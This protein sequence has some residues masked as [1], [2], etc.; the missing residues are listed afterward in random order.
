MVG[1]GDAFIA[2]VALTLLQGSGSP[3]PGHTVNL[4]LT[5]TDD[6]GL[7]YAIGSSLGTGPIPIDTRQ[8]DLSPDDL[9]VVTANN[10]LPAIFAGYRG[11]IGT[12]GQAQAAI[13]I[14]ADNRLIGVRI[15]TAFVTVS[16]SAPSGFKSISNTFSFT[17]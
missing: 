2:K 9:L 3:R 1:G 17:I 7:P 13:N 11:V 12:N 16:P 4:T 10:Y 15:H 14:P 5:A 6:V 8:I